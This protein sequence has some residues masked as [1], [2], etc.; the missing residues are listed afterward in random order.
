MLQ[1]NQSE[2]HSQAHSP[3]PKEDTSVL[4]PEMDIHMA[5]SPLF[6]EFDHEKLEFGKKFEDGGDQE[7]VRFYQPYHYYL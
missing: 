6:Q 4:E 2:I 1:K 5:T 3:H 7:S